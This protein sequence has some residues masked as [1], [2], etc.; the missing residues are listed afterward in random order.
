MQQ[1]LYGLGEVPSSWPVEALR[2]QAVA[3][4]TY[5][6]EKVK[7]LGQN[8][9]G[10]A[11]A[12]FR[13]VSDQ[14]YI[15]YEKEVGA[16]G[17]RWIAAVNDT[18][19]QT[20]THQGAPIQAY[21][22]SSS[23]GHTENSEFVFIEALPYL[24][25]VPDPYDSASGTNSLHTWK[26]DFTPRE[27]EAW[28]NSS[29]STSV[30]VLDRIE[31]VPPF[32]VSGRVIRKLDDSRGGVRIVGSS[33]T[34]HVNGDTFRSV[35]NERVGQQHQPAERAHAPRRLRAL[36]RVRG[37][38]VRG[39]RRARCGRARLDRHRRRRRR[40]PARPHLRPRRHAQRR[41]V[42]CLRLTLRRRC[43]RGRVRPLRRRPARGDR[44]RARPRRRPA[45]QDLLA[46][47]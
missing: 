15:G 39:R 28:M 5:T 2:A 18:N 35:V 7:R 25:G 42:L 45:R 41:R 36:R 38:R 1:Y 20:I 13:T 43:A 27:L 12:L 4:R 6:L 17:D 21:Y 46:G 30:G 47:G 44:H 10:C 3:G 33:G 11:C 32:G 29:S 34:K 16:S 23:G 31:F 24:R 9:P 22:S 40:W 37:R 14:N 26:R 8:R 19:D